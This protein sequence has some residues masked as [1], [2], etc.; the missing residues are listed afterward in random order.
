MNSDKSYSDFI[1]YL[2]TIKNKK[3]KNE[4]NNENVLD[5][6]EENI[7][8]D[9]KIFIIN[10]KE[11]QDSDKYKRDNDKHKRDNDKHKRD[12]D[13]HKRDND[14]HKRDN[15]K[16]KVDNDKHKRE[17]D[18]NIYSKDNKKRSNTK[19]D[20]DEN[21][22]DILF[23]KLEKELNNEF[24]KKNF[25]SEKKS[26]QE[27]VSSS[28]KKLENDSLSKNEN[29]EYCKNELD[30]MFE[31]ELIKRMYGTKK[32]SNNKD[33]KEKRDKIDK[34]KY[35][36]KKF[37]RECINE[38]IIGFNMDKKL[39]IIDM[40]RLIDRIKKY[41]IHKFQ[42]FIL[43]RRKNTWY[44]LTNREMKKL[45]PE[46]KFL[47]I[48]LTHFSLSK[49]EEKEEENDKFRKIINGYR[50]RC[51]RKI[52]LLHKTLTPENYGDEVEI[53]YCTRYKDEDR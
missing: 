38:S 39:C 40:E 52:F 37:Y 12:N 36:S 13:K 1:D 19:K 48:C 34:L 50:Y 20:Q 47:K 14:K 42:S 29:S 7:S 46:D 43:Y 51:C 41:S 49:D 9:K 16:H 15:D 6:I 17:N 18:K 11:K 5:D 23:K 22:N 35:E 32:E 2:D 45:L 30:K 10:N 3:I 28:D 8:N 31:E 44:S 21:I 4:K 27:S 53:V 33:N 24:K 25:D 26:D